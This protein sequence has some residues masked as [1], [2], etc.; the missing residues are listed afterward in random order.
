MISVA[1][2]R[3]NCSPSVQTPF[4]AARLPSSR[5]D[6][7]LPPFDPQRATSKVAQSKAPIPC[8]IRT[9]KRWSLSQP[10]NKVPS[11]Q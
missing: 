1:I 10:Y 11:L 8:E 4:P 3:A 6:A 9:S 7:L 2:A 5:I